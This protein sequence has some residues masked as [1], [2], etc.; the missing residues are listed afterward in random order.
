M[1]RQNCIAKTASHAKSVT[2]VDIPAF[3]FLFLYLSIEDDLV[4]EHFVPSTFLKSSSYD[5]KTAIS[6]KIPM[7]TEGGLFPLSRYYL[8]YRSLSTLALN[9][10]G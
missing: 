6:V 7:L 3:R 10:S 9:T 1:P 8:C 2:F 4:N 5:C